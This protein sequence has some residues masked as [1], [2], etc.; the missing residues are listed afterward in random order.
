[1]PIILNDTQNIQAQAKNKA[2]PSYFDKDL[3]GAGKSTGLLNKNLK[4]AGPSDKV[5]SLP[6]NIGD[7]KGTR[8]DGLKKYKAI[9]MHII[10][11]AHS[12]ELYLANIENLPEDAEDISDPASGNPCW[13]YVTA[14]GCVLETEQGNP[15]ARKLHTRYHITL[16][17]VQPKSD[18]S[19][20]DRYQAVTR[21][22]RDLTPASWFSSHADQAKIESYFDGLTVYDTIVNAA[23]CW[24][25]NLPAALSCWL[26]KRPN[27]TEVFD[28]VQRIN[29]TMEGRK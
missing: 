14:A 13:L 17:T 7:I 27:I 6:V 3:T 12:K 20:P 18:P 9:P 10:D 28:L 16:F 21:Y 4:P 22:V 24:Q 25:K 23:A 8:Q 11:V 15:S 19:E 29:R 1:M 26:A 2:K 5:E